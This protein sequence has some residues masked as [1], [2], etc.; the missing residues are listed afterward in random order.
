MGNNKS[1]RSR[2]IKQK[3]NCPNCNKEYEEKYGLRIH[4]MTCDPKYQT[5]LN[6]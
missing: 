1:K 2:A 4:R 6:N 5:N 3:A